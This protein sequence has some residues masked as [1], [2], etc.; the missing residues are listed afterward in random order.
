MVGLGVASS[1]WSRFSRRALAWLCR[2]LV[3]ALCLPTWVGLLARQ[4]WLAELATHF[5]WHYCWLLPLA[6]IGCALLRA[7][8]L[9][10]FTAITLA[11]NAAAVA[12]LF[13]PVARPAAEKLAAAPRLRV[14]TQNVL[15]QN[16]QAGLVV[17]LVRQETPDL[18]LLLEVNQRWIDAMAPLLDEYPHHCH[19]LRDTRSGMAVFSKQ[20]L[21]NVRFEKLTPADRWTLIAEMPHAGH[22]VTVI[23]LH[24]YHPHAAAERAW[25]DDNLHGAAQLASKAPGPVVVMGDLNVTP[26]TP[27][28]GDL[29][30]ESRLQDSLRG[31]GVQRSWSYRRDWPLLLPIDHVLHS[32]DMVVLN[33]RIGPYVGSD[34]R[35]VIVDLA[36]PATE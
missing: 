18:F 30:R 9:C 11:L 6:L 28:F 14:L 8:R 12:P 3:V 24:A 33:R 36:L 16:K 15:K 1:A 7:W 25:R 20:P 27:C 17:D 19:E 5:T 35:A 21:L 10:G 29:L 22:T 13:A 26:W 31:F 4:F 23:G 34:H 2:A 32:R